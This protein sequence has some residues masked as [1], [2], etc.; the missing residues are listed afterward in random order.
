MNAL[1]ERRERLCMARAISSFPVP[2]SPDIRA[3]E[4]VGATLTTLESTALRTGD[5]PTIAKLEIP[6]R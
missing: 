6:T 1:S 5:A 3:V 2:V 4:S